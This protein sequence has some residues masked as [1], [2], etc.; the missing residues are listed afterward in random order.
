M[1][2]L[3]VFLTLPFPRLSSFVFIIF[4]CHRGAGTK[5]RKSFGLKARRANLIFPP[6]VSQRKMT[7]SQKY[8]TS[9]QIKHKATF[10]FFVKTVTADIH[11][12]KI[13]SLDYFIT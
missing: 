10:I 12:H 11:S 5:H 4:S 2:A 8:F 7:L 6:K 13:L 9:F 1:F 3:N